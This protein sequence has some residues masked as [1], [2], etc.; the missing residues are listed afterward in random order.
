M[1]PHSGQNLAVPVFSRPH[2]HASKGRAIEA[3]CH[4]WLGGSVV[5]CRLGAM[6]T[7]PLLLMLAARLF[8]TVLPNV[9]ASVVCDGPRIS[10]NSDSSATVSCISASATSVVG[11]SVLPFAFASVVASAPGSI[12][13]AFV[14]ADYRLFIT[15]ANG[16]T[17]TPR[18]DT[19]HNGR[20]TDVGRWQVQFGTSIG[21]GSTTSGVSPPGPLSFTDGVPQILTLTIVTQAF[22][23]P[24]NTDTAF[25]YADFLGVSVTDGYGG[26]TIP[27]AVVS[28]EVVPEPSYSVAWVGLIVFGRVYSDRR[29]SSR[30]RDTVSFR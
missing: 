19:N 23:D 12:A 21:S 3:S 16:G 27:G 28:L 6:R 5:C 1:Q 14:Q 2:R 25:A 9:S 15:G 7:L 29:G 8:S 20:E 13:A 30:I 11:S 10:A 4:R 26:P 24:S 17:A 18:F 22:V